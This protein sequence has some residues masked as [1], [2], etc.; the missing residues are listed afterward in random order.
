M[1]LDNLTN[2]D[3]PFTVFLI[4]FY[5][6]VEFEISFL[7]VYQ[8]QESQLLSSSATL[9][10]QKVM[11]YTV[12]ALTIHILKMDL[13]PANVYGVL[14]TI[15]QWR[16]YNGRSNAVMSNTLHRLSVGQITLQVDVREFD[17]W[18]VA[19]RGRSTFSRSNITVDQHS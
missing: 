17:V 5:M 11:Q 8:V 2:A 9:C 7:C 16:M 10:M 18:Q 12:S 15:P 14:L 3:K 19:H 13:T 1:D 6:T 4:L